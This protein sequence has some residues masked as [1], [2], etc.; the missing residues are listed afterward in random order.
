MTLFLRYIFLVF[1]I[2]PCLPA[3]PQI[4]PW[5]AAEQMQKGINLGNTLEPPYEDGWN[6]PPAEEYYFDLYKNAGFQCVR[7]PVRW[8]KHT[9]TTSP[10]KIDESW[11]KRVEEVLE[12][13]LERDLFVV[14]N[15]HHDDWIKEN[16]EN[17]EMRAR[18][19]SIWAQVSRRLKNKSE[20]LI[21]EVLNEPHGL[22]KAQNDDMHARVLSIIRETNPTR[23]VIFQGH[24]WGGSDELI[25]AEVP[26]DEYVIGSFHSYDPYQF[27]LQGQ[28]SWGTPSDVTTL[29]NKFQRVKDWSDTHNI[30]VFLGEFGAINKCEY[31]SR[32]KHYK[33][34]VQFAKEF[35]FIYCA[36]DDGGDFRIMQRQS[37]GWNDIKNILL[38]TGKNS[39]AGPK[40]ELYQDTIMRLSWENKLAEADSICIERRTDLTN[41]WEIATLEPSAT[42][43]LDEALFPNTYYYYR[44]AVYFNNG[45]KLYSH[46]VRK[47]MPV[48]VPKVREPFKGSPLPIPGIIEAEDF[49][50]GGEG[51]SYHDGSE[52]NIGGAYRPEEGVDIYE[53]GDGEYQVGNIMPGEW[54]E[55]S[56]KIEK[57]GVY[58]LNVYTSAIQEGGSFKIKIGDAETSVL[59]AP[60]TNSWLTT[61]PVS[62][63]MELIKGEHIMRFTVIDDP[64]FNIDRFEISLDNTF[65]EQYQDHSSFMAYVNGEREIV[66]RF[67]N[68]SDISILNLFDIKGNLRRSIAYP[69]SDLRIPASGFENGI[70]IIQG[71]S[72]N[73]NLT[74]KI[75]LKQ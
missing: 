18:F 46:P 6:N 17:P 52:N 35:G 30:P 29:R 9:Q 57:D 12:W 24:N 38:H 33:F 14:V 32:M 49:D 69:S 61:T 56:V 7:V 42:E 1:L 62:T 27:G 36:W 37:R 39:P 74:Q 22:T 71:L 5:Q 50:I 34:Y 8:D 31:N 40:L 20:K 25:E 4:S 19:D 59:I 16:Y 21:F 15:A 23:I 53:T 60:N 45:E 11:L 73:M 64:L 75:I 72:N 28:G 41:F 26:D 65:T 55:Y 58:S 43:Y 66:I 47:L 67:G 3:K 51:L 63:S 48:Y 2:I 68:N 10:Y 54:Y 44:I 70:Y 13:G